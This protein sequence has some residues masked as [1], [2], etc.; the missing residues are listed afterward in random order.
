M[1]ISSIVVGLAKED[2]PEGLVALSALP[3]VEVHYLEPEQHRLV[4]TQETATTEQQEEGLRR[5]QAL[6]CVLHAA[7]VHHYFEEGD[8]EAETPAP[9]PLGRISR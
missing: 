2:F 3:G 5:I 6:P 9:I 7:L 4:V 1:N 8:G